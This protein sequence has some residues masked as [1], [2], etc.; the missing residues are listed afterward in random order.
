MAEDEITITYET[1]FDILRNEKKTSTVQLLPQNFFSEVLSYIEEKYQSLIKGKTEDLFIS[2]DKEKHL[3]ELNNLK[4][5]IREIIERRT[6]KIIDLAQ[7]SVKAQEPADELK[8]LLAEEQVL[9]RHLRDVLER[10]KKGVSD[11]LI[12]LSRPDFLHAQQSTQEK[13]EEEK[14]EDKFVL[15]RIISPVPRFIGPDLKIYGPFSEEEIVK[16]P[17]DITDVLIRK[18]RA[19]KI[20]IK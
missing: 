19:E 12:N 17:K 7:I 9:Y 2:I 3:R 11:K 10:Y 18:A 15:V 13:S 4:A 6:K 5:I 16:M 14:S 8:N 20:D 1:L